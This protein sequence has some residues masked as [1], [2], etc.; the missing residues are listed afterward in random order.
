MKSRLA[1]TIDWLWGP[2]LGVAIIAWAI[3]GNVGPGLAALC[4][5][6]GLSFILAVPLIQF[7]LIRTPLFRGQ[8]AAAAGVGIFTT[9][10]VMFLL[11]RSGE[12]DF[13]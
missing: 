4:F 7:V 12:F 1:A 5:L 13:W 2:A 3:I 6:S 9:I 8:L 10:F 11:A